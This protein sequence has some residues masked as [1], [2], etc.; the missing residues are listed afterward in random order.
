VELSGIV[1]LPVSVADNTASAF[2][3]LDG[4]P[5]LARV[6][7]SMLGAV[8]EPG[9]I[10]VAAAESLI[11]DV[12]AVLVSHDLDGVRVSAVGGTASRGDCIRTALEALQRASFS[13][14]HVLV[15]DISSPL[16]SVDLTARVVAA[17]RGGDIVTPILSVTDSVKAVDANGAITAT[18]D[19]AALRALQYPRGFAVEV[20][21][22]LL[23]QDAPDDVD[24]IA[25]AVGT[26]AH[27]T[28]VE[29]DPDAYHVELPRDAE[30]IEAL[31]ACREPD[32]LGA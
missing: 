23:G 19:R 6:V 1:P 4:A 5:A 21:A 24:E 16:A 11:D 27:I 9:R 25:E 3:P 17:M 15:H 10:V 13:T 7:S 29:G 2:L 30:F 14:S 20:L 31:I 26:G 22:G 18:V 8:A 28:V 12:R 32:P